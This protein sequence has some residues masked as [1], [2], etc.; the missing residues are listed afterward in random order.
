ML[1]NAYRVGAGTF[2]LIASAPAC[3]ADGP[4]VLGIPVDCILF[5]LTLLGVALFHRHTLRVAL[6]GLA[7]ITLYKLAFTG[8]KTGGGILGLLAHLHHEWVILT[9]LLCLLLGFALLSRH[10]EK[11]HLPAVLPRFLPH[12]WKGCFAL[13][14]PRQHRGQEIGRAH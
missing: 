9:N 4:A 8:F 3:A 5:G 7:V 11:T 1:L 10:F 13:Q 6:A 12:D 14:E 2:A